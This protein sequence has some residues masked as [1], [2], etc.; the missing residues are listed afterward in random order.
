MALGI[1]IGYQ[2]TKVE[3]EYDTEKQT[4]SDPRIV[5]Q[6]FVTNYHH[7][8]D[9]A[10]FFSTP[11]FFIILE[12]ASSLIQTMIIRKTMNPKN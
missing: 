9:N 10:S 3:F 11:Q 2:N 5:I 7:L 12:P 1:G 8:N 6:P 4:T